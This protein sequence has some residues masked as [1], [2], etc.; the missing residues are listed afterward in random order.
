MPE[1]RVLYQITAILSH[2]LQEESADVRQRVG[3][4]VDDMIGQLETEQAKGLSPLAMARGTQ[5]SADTM[6][7]EAK[8]NNPEAPNIQCRKGCAACCK[9]TVAITGDEAVQLVVVA[10]AKDIPLDRDRLVRQTHYND[11]TWA[12]QPA[13]DRACPFLGSDQVCQVYHDRPLS[14]RKYFVISNPEYCDTVVHPKHQA[15]VWFDASA[16]MLT[17]AAFTHAGCGLMPEMLL[18]VIDLEA[19]YVKT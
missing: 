14:C 3:D 1:P 15:Q 2:L 17:T 7:A 12:S 6:I 10:K 19:H 11:E 16:E 5:R 13:E 9:Q 4:A 8:A 18:G